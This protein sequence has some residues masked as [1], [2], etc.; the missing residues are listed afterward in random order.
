MSLLNNDYKVIFD[1]YNFELGGSWDGLAQPDQ[2]FH[3]TAYVN[4][5]MKVMGYANLLYVVTPE[6][7]ND[8]VPSYLYSRTQGYNMHYNPVFGENTTPE[9]YRYMAFKLC[10]L[11]DIMATLEDARIIRPFDDI[12]TDIKNER[13]TFCE[14]IICTGH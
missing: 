4:N 6:N 11:F 12:L 2:N 13:I 7:C 1:K 5:C 8:V 10:E 9:Q 14:D 3:H